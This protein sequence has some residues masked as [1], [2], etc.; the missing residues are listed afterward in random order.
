MLR[1]VIILTFGPEKFL[2][3]FYFIWCFFVNIALLMMFCLVISL[4]THH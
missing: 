2:Y 3:N 4:L 1:Y